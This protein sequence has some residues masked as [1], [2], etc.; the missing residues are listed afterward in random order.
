VY[1][2]GPQIDLLGNSLQNRIS[3]V[4]DEIIEMQA[5]GTREVNA[6]RACRLASCVEPQ[7][8]FPITKFLRE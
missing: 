8:K 3:R 1:P 2:M 4:M 7:S 6:F 5:F